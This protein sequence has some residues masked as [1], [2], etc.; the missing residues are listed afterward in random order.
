[1]QQTTDK[2][3]MQPVRKLLGDKKHLLIAPEGTLNVVPF[4]AFV[5]ENGKYLIEN[6]ETTH[7]T[8]GSA[9]GW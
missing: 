1:M 6:Y 5:D 9:A 3:V 2:L 8:S 4:D 7:L